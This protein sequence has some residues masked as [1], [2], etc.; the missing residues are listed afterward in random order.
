LVALLR[1]LAQW[2]RCKVLLS[3][4]RDEHTWLG[5]LPAR[6]RL[7]GMP[8]RESLQLAAALGARHSHGIGTADWRPLLRYAAGNPLTITVLVGQ[9][10]R[11]NLSTTEAIETFVTHLQAGEA[12]LE[13]GEDAA[14]GRTGS[15][16]ASLS[17][18]FA[19]A[20]TSEERAQLAVLHLFR[21][22]VDVDAL[23]YIGDP[24][25]AGEDAVP[26]LA[27]LDREAGIALLDRAA[28]IGLLTSLGGGYY[29]IHP[30]LPWYFTTLYT[31][32]YGP[33]GG[34][35]AEHAGRAYTQAIGD[36]GDY[37]HSEA[38]SGRAGQVVGA[39]RAE[40]ANLRH[41]LDLARAAG[42]WSAAVGCLQGLSILYER[43]GRDSE[44][45]RLVAGITPDFTDPA[46]GGPLPGRENQWSI[47]I[48]YRVRLARWA[49]DWATATTLQDARIA[50]DRDRA[51]AA[52]GAPAAGLAPD[53]RN[54]IRNLA[55]SLNE[56]GNIL[57]LQQ[58]PG[59][60]AHF[61]ESLKL[62]QRIGNRPAEAQRAGS[63]G[64]AYLMVPGLRNLDQAEHWF[65]HS[66]SLRPGNDR[67][68]RAT[69][70]NQIG[71][72]ALHR[73]D[74]ARAAGEAEPVLLEH[75]KAALDSYQQAL[76][77][78]PVD[79][80]ETRGV[81][82]NQLGAIYAK[83]GDTRQALR[84]YQQAIKHDEARGDI[85]GAGQ[86]RYNIAVLLAGDGRTSD[87]L[88]YARAALD[89]YQQAGP[90]AADRADRARRLIADLEQRNG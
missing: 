60:L 20:F 37:Y 15:L 85:Y 69:G 75:L 48:E 63:L 27:G 36:L 49:R 53:Q 81:T 13:A 87:S 18:G 32:A 68:G 62:A 22:T 21:D 43:T 17:H 38:Q 39:L 3:S 30:A 40:E 45:A 2:T 11:D 59:C 47:I 7:P 66:L 71:S 5:D 70:L 65:R 61:Q 67:L 84:H 56:L 80:H 83:A 16:A 86:A 78:T 88:H 34:P 50:W 41:A 64:N 57:L 14:L 24:D 23:R 44:W 29:Q 90:G 35:A 12:Q 46:T 72:V 76:D 19:Q 52:L 74:D 77:L 55:V 25:I 4:R 33:P 51:A 31:T 42:F 8:L 9:A 10:L 58:D 79:D 82:E 6:V 28:G 1:D 73:F 54:Q 26:E 89:N